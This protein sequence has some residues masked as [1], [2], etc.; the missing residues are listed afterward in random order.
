MHIPPWTFAVGFGSH[1]P[2]RKRKLLVHR[3]ELKKWELDLKTQPLTMVPLKVYFK[4]GRCKVELALARGQKSWDRRQ[5][6][7]KRDAE[8]D[9]ARETKRSERYG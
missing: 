9:L 6:I 3:D 2:D 4:D 5:A 8:R 7:A 1:D